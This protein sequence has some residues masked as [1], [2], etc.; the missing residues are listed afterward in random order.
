[1]RKSSS[2]VL[3]AIAVLAIGAAAW[4]GGDFLWTKLLELHGIHRAT[5]TRPGTAPT[6]W[7][8]TRAGAMARN[9]VAAF[10]A[11]IDAMRKFRAENLAPEVMPQRT[12]EER[13][14][15]YRGLRGR[16]GD[17]SL[18][19]VVSS[20]AADLEVVLTAADGSPQNFIFAV[21]KESP[22]KLLEVR[23]REAHHFP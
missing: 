22:W 2:L 11:G 13:D 4:R 21:E 23:I 20:S 7:P 1:M 8:A 16:L 14:D 5:V 3:V 12:E 18:S 19:S 6:E 15:S 10:N 17:L 9:W